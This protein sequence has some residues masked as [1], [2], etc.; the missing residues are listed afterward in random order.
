MAEL[1][2]SALPDPRREIIKIS[3]DATVTECVL[4]MTRLNIGALLVCDGEDVLGIVT[5]RDVLNAC[6]SRH[7]SPDTKT[8]RDIMFTDVSIFSANDPIDVV[9]ETMTKTKRRHV[10]V[11]EKGKITAILS[12]GDVVFHMLEDKSRVIE[13]LER[14]IHS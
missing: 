14:Y 10:L 2:Y 11:Q 9:M 1:I 13:H 7:L 3:P 5:E 6:I 8:A 12:I 4:R